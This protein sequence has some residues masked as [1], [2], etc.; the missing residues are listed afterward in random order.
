MCRDRI[1]K[2]M[3]RYKIDQIEAC[4]AASKEDTDPCEIECNPDK[5]NALPA[6]YPYSTQ[7]LS[8]IDLH[9]PKFQRYEGVAIV[10]KVHWPNDI[11]ILKQMLCLASA[12][13][14]RHVN[15]DIIVFST[16]PW[17]QE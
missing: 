8:K 10:T 9:E 15:Y 5:C 17:N 7:D 4:T 12:A 13:Y 6:G 11:P 14:N 16:I 3:E 1:L 2:L